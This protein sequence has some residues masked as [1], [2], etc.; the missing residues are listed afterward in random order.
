LWSAQ[1]GLLGL[2]WLSSVGAVTLARRGVGVAQWDGLIRRATSTPDVPTT[3]AGTF[4]SPLRAQ[5]WLEWRERRYSYLLLL[6]LSLVVGPAAAECSMMAL[7]TA[8]LQESAPGLRRAVELAGPEWLS[9][10]QLFLIPIMIALV[11]GEDLG[12]LGPNRQGYQCSSFLAVRPVDDAFF[13]RLKLRVVA[14][15]TLAA[16]STFLGAALLW[17]VLRGHGTA[18]ADRLIQAMGSPERALLLIVWALAAA[19][20]L[21][22]AH[23]VQDLWL[24][25]AGRTWLV[26]VGL[27]TALVIWPFLG[28]LVWWVM[29]EE[30]RQQIARSLLPALLAAGLLVKAAASGTIAA[31]LVR[32]GMATGK[33][34]ALILAAWL[35]GFALVAGLGLWVVPPEW[36]VGWLVAGLV[37]LGLPLARWGLAPFAVAWNRHR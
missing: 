35:S 36:G 21:S 30:A 6:A 13:V 24:G 25:L 14:L 23:L 18:L 9:L 17:A 2:A 34:L 4:A 33:D 16:W 12:K 1:V 27:W 31:L 29:Q 5:L 20:V 19:L 11:S 7:S 3:R 32:R 22:W 37:A 28:W 26:G 8:G 15:G 10:T